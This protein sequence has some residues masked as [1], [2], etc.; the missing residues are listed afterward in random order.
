LTGIEWNGDKEL[1]AD[2]RKWASE[3]IAIMRKG[4]DHPNEPGYL[5]LGKVW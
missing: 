4:A 2:A 1:V 3:L 5:N